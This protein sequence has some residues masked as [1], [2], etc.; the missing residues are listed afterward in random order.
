[1]KPEYKIK[2]EELLNGVDKKIDV[3][4]EML[5]GKRPADQR[6]VTAYCRDIKQSIE[7][8]LNLISIS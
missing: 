1:M 4:T 8:T 6:L 5:S 3:I 7:S 2:S